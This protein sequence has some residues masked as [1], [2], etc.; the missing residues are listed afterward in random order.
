MRRSCCEAPPSIGN[1]LNQ[2]FFPVRWSATRAR[3]FGRP[4][5]AQNGDNTCRPR[6]ACCWSTVDCVCSTQAF[7]LVDGDKLQ[8]GCRQSTR[9]LCRPAA[10]QCR[11]C[12]GQS[13]SVRNTKRF[14]LS[15]RN[16]NSDWAFNEATNRSPSHRR[17][18]PLNL[19]QARY[20]DRW[21]P[22]EYWRLDTRHA[23]RQI[24]C[25]ASRSCHSSVPSV[26][27]GHP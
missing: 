18:N 12:A 10:A 7:L 6:P 13:R 20:A 9:Q 1:Y 14:P 5:S 19:K 11:G 17:S 3:R 23:C 8:F 24:W 15:K 27:I 22:G 16:R 2:F 4:W 25:R 21:N 26:T